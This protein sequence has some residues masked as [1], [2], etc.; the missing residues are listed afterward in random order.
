MR[1]RQL[2]LTYDIGTT[3]NKCTIFDETGCIIGAVIEEY[4]TYYPRPGWAEQNPEDFVRSIV[5]GT[6]RIIDQY[7]IPPENIAVIG[8]SGHMNGCI[9][10]DKEGRVLFNNIIHSDTRTGKQCEDILNRFNG[11]EIYNIT[12]NR[13]DPHYTLPK[14]LW[15]KEHYPEVY[16]NSAYILNTKD[17]I[18]YWLTGNLGI[19]DLSDASLTCMLDI[20]KGTW[21]QEFVGEVGIDT[22]KLPRLF[23]SHDLAGG[24]TKE[25]AAALGLKEGTPVVVGGGDGPCATKGAGVM[26]KGFAYNYIGS[27]SWI[28]TLSDGPVLD[29]KARIF[30]FYDLDGIH[31]DVTGTVQCATISYDWVKDNLGLYEKELAERNQES[32][33]EIIQRMAENSP[34]GSNG[35]F[36]L[37]YLMGERTPYWD[38]NTR[39]AFI[40]FTLFHKREDLFRSVYE[41]IT[42]ALRSVLDV[43]EENGLEIRKLTLIGG[44]AKSPL[45]NEIMCNIYGKS[46]AV[47][48]YPGE[49]TSLGAAIAAGVGVGIF[50]DYG[51]AA[52]IIR[53]KRELVPEPS[54][55]EEYEKYYQVYKMM[56]PQLKP[57]Y[58][59]ISQL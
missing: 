33:F 9:P 22:N 48:S 8:L 43:F 31:C 50:K 35:V 3:G 45:W 55:V 13:I 18:S 2:I 4:D 52:K 10:V 26:Y 25:A 20:K 38:K 36:F 46:L 5:N 15:L 37:P 6:R 41:G 27:S 7:K 58:Q 47:H 17:Y 30:N 1:E 16:R 57:I 56:Y 51:E 54:K 28:S 23:R 12:G 14:I 24:L 32:V 40:G 11:M 49:A 19:T 39:G 21:A 53:Y 44:G 34:I 29:Q 42:Y 59:A